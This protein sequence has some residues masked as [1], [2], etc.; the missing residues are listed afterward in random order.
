MPFKEKINLM[1]RKGF[2]LIELLVVI[3]IIAILAAILFP[4]FAQAREKARQITCASNL[5][6]IGIATMMYTQDNDELFYPHRWTPDV[7]GDNPFCTSGFTCSTSEGTES[8]A[9]ITGKAS[10]RIFWV[11]LLQPYT[12]SYGVF[13]CP[14]NPNAW[15]GASTEGAPV[16]CGGGSGSTTPSGCDGFGYGGQNSYAHNDFWMSPAANTVP[17][18][19]QIATPSSTVLVTDGTYY[20]GG[21]DFTGESGLAIN[22]NGTPAAAATDSSGNSLIAD[23]TNFVEAQSTAN[24][25][26]YWMNI[27]NSKMGYNV[28]PSGAWS[29][30]GAGTALSNGQTRHSGGLVNVQF[31]D[32]HVKSIQYT[33]LISNMC[34]WVTDQHVSAGAVA[35]ATS[36]NKYCNGSN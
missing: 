33:R 12:K 13:K 18:N 35:N 9:Q 17:S 10:G 30:P 16:N 1:N 27:G 32:G 5:K 3:A 4:V 36:H 2:T 23:D 6:Q 11:S 22:Y 20:G 15:V 14:D 19:A 34:Y 24:Y 28:T 21:P 31:D 25:K 26:D 8:G 29:T 7:A